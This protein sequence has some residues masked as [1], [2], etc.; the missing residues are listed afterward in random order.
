MSRTRNLL[1]SFIS[2]QFCSLVFSLSNIYFIGCVYTG[3]HSGDIG[4]ESVHGHSKHFRFGEKWRRCTTPGKG[5]SVWA[6]PFILAMLPLLVRFVQ[7]VKRY[8]DSKLLTHIINVSRSH[9]IVCCSGT[10]L[11]VYRVESMPWALFTMHAT[12]IG[13]IPAV[14]KVELLLRSGCSSP[15]FMHVTLLHGYVEIYAG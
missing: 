14:S 11:R 4:T 15:Q 1:I 2:D 7:S 6:L 13:G 9:N 3:G 8:A 10:D 5:S 12:T